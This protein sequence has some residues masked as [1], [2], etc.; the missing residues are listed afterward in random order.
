[1]NTNRD[2]YEILGVSKNATQEE[3]KAA[4]R[5]LALK[6]H[7]DRNPNNK[8]AEEKFK[9]A[10]AAYEVLSDTDKRKR[11]DQ[12]GHAGIEGNMGMGRQ[13]MNMEDIFEHFGDI[14]GDIFGMG[15]RQTRRK[16]GPTP[17]R[18]H[19]LSQELQITLKEAY[20]GTKK[21]VGIYQFVA[22]EVCGGKGMEKGTS[23]QTC[24]RCSGTGQIQFKQGFFMYAQP[25]DVCNGEGFTIPSPCKACKGQSRIQ[26]FDKFTVNIPKGIFDGAELR[27][28]GKGDAGVYGGQSGDLFIHVTVL[29]DKTFSRVDDDLVCTIMLTYPQLVLGSQI[30]IENIDGTKET[31]K[32]PKGCP[33][34]EKIIAVGKGFQRLRSKSY[35][36]LVVIT[37]CHIPKKLSTEAKKLL[38]DYSEQIGTSTDNHEG[39]IRSFFKK[40][41]G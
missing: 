5:K 21:E 17:K 15:Q 9:E 30:D 35:G 26:K 10:A 7:P 41:L 12:F 38:T 31:I 6:Y 1:M 14:F 3:I 4:Y 25:C 39:S 40:F 29:P 27:I 13:D 2:Y 32:I 36:N 28:S 24:S 33:V 37:N 8:E 34:G 19:D 22:C 20:T 18:G 11:Y 23:A 16:T